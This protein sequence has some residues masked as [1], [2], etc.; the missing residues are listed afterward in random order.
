VTSLN[1]M[2]SELRRRRGRTLLTALGLA[3]GVG[4]VITVSAL[5]AGL[6]DAQATVLKPLTGI[7]T[8]MSVT[9]PLKI[10]NS[11]GGFRGLSATE[12]KELQQENGG[13]RLDFTKLKPGS[14]F[15]QYV[16]NST[17]QLSFPATK[18][19]TIRSLANVQGAVGGLTLNA[20]HITGT[21]PTQTQGQGGGFGPGGGGGAAGGFA[22]PRGSTSRRSTF[23]A[24]T[25]RIRT[26]EPSRPARSRA[27]ATSPRAPSARRSS[28]SA[29]RRRRT[30]ESATRSPSAARRSP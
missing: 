12:R 9:R 25:S 23:R 18:V 26:S 29:T 17:S 13:G 11:S 1:Y 30:S 15:S 14:H 8:D 16:F 5:S 3:I 21:V 7:G 28:T 22:G 10:S 20:A 2:F 4:L 6:D 24:S 27:A 19:S